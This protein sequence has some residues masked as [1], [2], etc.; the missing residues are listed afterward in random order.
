MKKDFCEQLYATNKDFKEYVDKLVNDDHDYNKF[1]DIFE[2]ETVYQ[3]GLY[4]DKK[5]KEKVEET[6]IVKFPKAKEEDKSC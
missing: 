3:V 2:N 5:A 6:V 1:P 4:Y